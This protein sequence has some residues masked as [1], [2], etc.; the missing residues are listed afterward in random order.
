MDITREANELV[1]RIPLKAHR[2]DPFEDRVYGERDNI[3]GVIDWNVKYI[4]PDHAELG[5]MYLE[6]FAY[7]GKDDQLTDWAIKYP[8]DIEDFRKLCDKLKITYWEI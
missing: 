7:K 1:V 4:G 2:Y 5:F 8:G 6:D 3:V